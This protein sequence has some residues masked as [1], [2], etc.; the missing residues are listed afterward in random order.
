MVRGLGYSKTPYLLG[1]NGDLDATRRTVN[2]KVG[3]N[4]S[5]S[6]NTYTLPPAIKPGLSDYARISSGRT[7]AALVAELSGHAYCA[8]TLNLGG[9][10]KV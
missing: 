3:H 4:F 2:P 7:L 1:N 9:N 6:W 8:E 5:S 10:E